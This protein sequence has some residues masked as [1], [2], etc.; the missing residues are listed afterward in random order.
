MLNILVEGE[1]IK[2]VGDNPTAQEGQEVHQIPEEDWNT[3]AADVKGFAKWNMKW[4]I[5]NLKVIPK[6]QQEI[7]DYLA[8]LENPI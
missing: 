5:I 3:V 4:D 8:S 1:E 7:D 2:S 6:T